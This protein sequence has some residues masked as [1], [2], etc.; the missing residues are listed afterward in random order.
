MAVGL[1]LEGPNAAAS[2]ASALIRHWRIVIFTV[3]KVVAS[4]KDGIRGPRRLCQTQPSTQLTQDVVIQV[5][6]HFNLTYRNS[7]IG[8]QFIH[9]AYKFFCVNSYDFGIVGKI[10][11]DG[12]KSE[13]T[14]YAWSWPEFCESLTDFQNNIFHRKTLW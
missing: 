12:Q 11:H 9:I 7:C 3:G 4:V 13:A 14:N 2:I 6:K 5:S 1:F 10:I 8:L